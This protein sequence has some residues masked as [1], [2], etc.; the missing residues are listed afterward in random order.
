MKIADYTPARIPTKKG[1]RPLHTYRGERRRLGKL[2][3][4]AKL[5]AP[6]DVLDAGPQLRMPAP[7]P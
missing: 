3:R 7:R 2:I 5:K 1:E 6:S 4:R